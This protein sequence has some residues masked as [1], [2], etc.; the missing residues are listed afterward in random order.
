MGE[1]VTSTLSKQNNSMELIKSKTV[2]AALGFIALALAVYF[3]TGDVD[4]AVELVLTG[5]GFLGLRQA[6]KK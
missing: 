1:A 4:K 2:W 5:V 3:K 6:V